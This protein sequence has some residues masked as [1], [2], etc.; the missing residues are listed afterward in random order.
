VVL[1]ECN[2][3]GQ[4]I[5]RE[6]LESDVSRTHVTAVRKERVLFVLNLDDGQALSPQVRSRANVI[7]SVK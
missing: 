4:F 7:L 3:H 6:Y 1:V 2:V 5:L